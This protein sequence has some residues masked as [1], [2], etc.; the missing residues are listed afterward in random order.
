MEEELGKDR[1]DGGME[2][3]GWSSRVERDERQ[4]PV[5]SVFISNKTPSRTPHS[6]G[7]TIR[8]PTRPRASKQE[9]FQ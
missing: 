4:R 1:M 2:V 5:A 7:Y 9:V 6:P 8:N 3:G